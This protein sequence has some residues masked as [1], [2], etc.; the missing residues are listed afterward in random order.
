MVLLARVEVGTV[1]D[2]VKLACQLGLG[3]RAFGSRGLLPYEHEYQILCL[4]RVPARVMRPGQRV[5]REM[6]GRGRAA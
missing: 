6:V 4:L 5:G 1:T 2:A 3:G